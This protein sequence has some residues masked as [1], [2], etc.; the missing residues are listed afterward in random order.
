MRGLWQA[1]QEPEWFEICKQFPGGEDPE[2]S[3]NITSAQATFAALQSGAQAQ[4]PYGSGWIGGFGS[5]R[6]RTPWYR[7]RRHDVKPHGT[8]TNPTTNNLP[9][10]QLLPFP[11]KTCDAYKALQNSS[12]TPINRRT[13]FHLLYNFYT[14]RHKTALGG[15]FFEQTFLES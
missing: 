3:A 11:H 4:Q 5:Q 7:R 6:R 14:T 15:V 12:A 1:I 13:W 2:P 9:A 8:F 10:P